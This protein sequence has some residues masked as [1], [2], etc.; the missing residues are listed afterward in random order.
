[1]ILEHE[2]IRSELRGRFKELQQRQTELDR[3]LKD[4]QLASTEDVLELESR[5]SP[6]L[7]YVESGIETVLLQ[8]DEFDQTAEEEWGR[9]REATEAEW[10]RLSDILDDVEQT[11]KFEEDAAQLPHGR[12]PRDVQERKY[13]V[14]GR[15]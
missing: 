10:N 15:R 1:M 13:S 5:L 14:S 3:R 6:D 12:N 9:L 4:A 7:T 2:Y 8:L 11:L